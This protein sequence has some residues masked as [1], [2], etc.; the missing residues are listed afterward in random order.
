MLLLKK[1]MLS[2]SK[3]SAMEIR[4]AC[5]ISMADLA[6]YLGKIVA[7]STLLFTRYE[8]STFD[9]ILQIPIGCTI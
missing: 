5:R 1:H 6:C 4:H 8:E 2:K 3:E 7:C 9:K